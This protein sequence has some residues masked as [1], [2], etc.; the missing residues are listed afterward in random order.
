MPLF[1]PLFFV[2]LAQGSM[3]HNKDTVV[4]LPPDSDLMII[5]PLE[6]EP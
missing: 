1:F 3:T 6:Q 4:V 5:L 2:L